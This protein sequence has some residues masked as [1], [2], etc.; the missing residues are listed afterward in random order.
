MTNINKGTPLFFTMIKIY[1]TRHSKTQWNEEKRLQ[2]RKDSSLTQEG[3]EN[4][5]ALKE[6][7]SHMRFDYIY[8]SPILRAYKTAKI[9]FDNQN[10]IQDNRLMEM[11]FGI[12]E[13]Q[14]IT[15]I[16]KENHD[17]YYQLWHEPEKFTCIP[18][19]ESYGQVIE[20]V[21]SFL[22][23]IQQLP[24]HS[25]IMIITHGMYFIVLLATMLGLEKKEFVKLNQKVVDGCSLTCVLY[26]HGVYTL[27]FYNECSFL[28]HIAN[29]SFS[30]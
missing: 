20:R 18:E 4:A 5:H 12:F 23:D 25:Q 13:G 6:Y 26:D 27:D 16:L 7:I 21:H 8:S 3:I 1:L 28:P 29:E 22:K 15:D 24:D 17:L 14:K 11:N 9:I 30:K 10:I 2:G 19:G